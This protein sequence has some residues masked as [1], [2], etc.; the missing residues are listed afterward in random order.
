[1][2]IYSK[3]I[4]KHFKNPK[5]M[6][7]I[8][9]ADGIGVA[10]NPLCGDVMEFFLKIGENKN[11]EKIIKDIKF[12]TLGCAVAI[13]NASLLTVMIKGKTVEEALKI[14]KKD[15]LEKLGKPLPPVKI[16]CSVLAIE[17]LYKAIR[18]YLKKVS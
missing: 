15:L 3:E 16:H 12:K 8:K 18:D 7:E 2:L 5:N 13:A 6:G 4:L 1:M 14:K 10:G 9:G 11:K 17:A